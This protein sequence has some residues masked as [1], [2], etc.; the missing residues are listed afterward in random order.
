[1]LLAYLYAPFCGHLRGTLNF[2]GNRGQC[3]DDEVRHFI[4]PA[5]LYLFPSQ[6]AWIE[7]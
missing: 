6:L 5:P 1:M 7:V 4:L 2:G 3:L